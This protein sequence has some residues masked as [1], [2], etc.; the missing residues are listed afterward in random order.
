MVTVNPF[1]VRILP[2]YGRTPYAMGAVSLCS[3]T[4][5]QILCLSSDLY[6]PEESS[7]AQAPYQDAASNQ[8]A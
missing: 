3:N 1:P 7:L 2:N 8:L 6:I 4:I 5:A